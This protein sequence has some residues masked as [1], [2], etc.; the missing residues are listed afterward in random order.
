[1]E[2]L[3]DQLAEIAPAHRA[4]AGPLVGLIAFGESLV[5]VGV[6]LPGTAALII[7]G[8]LV[9]AGLLEPVPVLIGAAV[10][11]AMGDIVSYLLGASLGRGAT[12]QW[13]LNRYR[14]TVA[15]ARLFF[16]RYGVAAI[17]LGRFFGPVRSAIPFV[18]GMM[19]M[20]WNR[21][22][23]ANLASAIVWAPVVL[24]PGW[25]VGRGAA[26]VIETSDTYWVGLAVFVI[27]PAIVAA[28]V[29]VRA[30]Q[31]S[32]ARRRLREARKSLATQ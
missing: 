10:G 20:Q 28:L 13:P 19:R 2:A 4:W 16:Q 24:S 7:V 12:R 3:I 31:Q 23:I 22:Q 18:A 21:F 29:A 32:L 5:L 6:L 1:M 9:G 27:V 26:N 25:L 11:A 14:E 8:G 30:I 17:F 15:R